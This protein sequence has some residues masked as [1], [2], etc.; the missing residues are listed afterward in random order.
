MFCWA[1][2]KSD[3]RR[4]AGDAGDELHV[5][6]LDGKLMRRPF[7]HLSFRGASTQRHLH[8]A[9]SRVSYLSARSWTLF[10][11]CVTLLL[12]TIFLSACTRQQRIV[13]GCKNFTEQ[14]ILGELIAQQI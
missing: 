9:P 4:N 6:R 8:F 7:F 1:G 3:W 11:V 5:A 13:V 14:I 12:A 10:L 2:W